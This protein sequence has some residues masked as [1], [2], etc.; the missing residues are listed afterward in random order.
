MASGRRNTKLSKILRVGG[1]SHVVVELEIGN[2]Q[3]GA[4]SL[5]WERSDGLIEERDDVV[6][7]DAV[8]RYDLGAGDDVPFSTLDIVVLV[9]DFNPATTMTSVGVRVFQEDSGGVEFFQLLS[10]PA[11]DE[12]AIVPYVL[13]L[14]FARG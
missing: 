8:I 2:G 10:A 5:I 14:T 7:E 1:D 13:R 9:K 11:T 6:L 3:G 4:V 12:N